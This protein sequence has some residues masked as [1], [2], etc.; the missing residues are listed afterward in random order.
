LRRLLTFAILLSTLLRCGFAAQEIKRYSLA[1]TRNMKV[2][3]LLCG[4]ILALAVPFIVYVLT[5]W[6]CLIISFQFSYRLPTLAGNF[7]SFAT[8]IGVFFFMQ[9]ARADALGLTRGESIAQGA[10]FLVLLIPIL[11][12]YSM[13]WKS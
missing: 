11:F 6:A 4:L 5:M 12:I 10:L 7:I 3:R 2:T 13:M 9:K 1:K 8:A